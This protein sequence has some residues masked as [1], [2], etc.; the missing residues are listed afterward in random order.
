VKHRA[1]SPVFERSL[2]SE[3]ASR[4]LFALFDKGP[5]VALERIA[6]GAGE[7]WW[8]FCEGKDGLDLILGEL[9][10]GSCV[11]FDFD[12]RIRQVPLEGVFERELAQWIQLDGEAVVGVLEDSFH[13]SAYT[14]SGPGDLADFLSDL[15][16]VPSLFAGRY[17]GRDNDGIRAVTFVVPDLDGIIRDHPH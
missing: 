6:F 7:T 11:S 5:A 17:P 13:L 10:P 3:A 12:Q 16:P 2:R 4:G 9:S 14:V 15:T 1:T 8:Y